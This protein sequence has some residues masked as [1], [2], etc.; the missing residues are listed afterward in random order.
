MGAELTVLAGDVGGS[1]TRLALAAPGVGVTALQ[2]FSNDSFAS[3][4]DV[5]RAYCAQPGLP[6]LAG[7]CLAVAGPVRDGH[8]ELSNR[9]WSG[10]AEEL[11]AVLGLQPG[12]KAQIINDLA[13]LGHALQVLIPGQ[14]ASLRPGRQSGAQALVAG[15][16]T[17]FNVAASCGEETLEAELG[18]AALPQ[19]LVHRLEQL[20]KRAPT[21]FCSVESL[22][23]GHGLVR[24]HQALSG[25]A[26]SSAEGISA[27]YLADPHGSEARTIGEWAQLLGLLAREMTALYMPGQG[28][29]FAGSVA[30]GILNTSARDLFLSSYTAPGGKLGQI[31]GD[32]PLW[33]IKD[34]AA[35]VSGAARVALRAAAAEDALSHPVGGEAQEQ[36]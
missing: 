2:S 7:A 26:A 20:L 12:A 5:L 6:P 9:N 19:P 29:F 33:L 34:D 11:A 13:A 25:S 18:H 31:C 21:E 3:L 10:R 23:S 35:G 28:M 24:F 1:R 32:T 22:F 16:G 14:L 17:G 15:I 4:E 36:T 30:R 8:F 27:A